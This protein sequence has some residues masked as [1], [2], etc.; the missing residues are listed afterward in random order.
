MNPFTS[1]QQPVVGP[2]RSDRVEPLIRLL[3]R[4]QRWSRS[5]PP[6]FKCDGTENGDFWTTPEIIGLFKASDLF[7]QIL[8]GRDVRQQFPTK[9]NLGTIFDLGVTAQSG[10]TQY[11][12]SDHT[13]SSPM[14]SPQLRPSLTPRDRMMVS[15]IRDCYDHLVCMFNVL[16][17][18]ILQQYQQMQVHSDILNTSGSSIRINSPMEFSD[19]D[20]VQKVA[21][22]FEQVDRAMHEGSARLAHVEPSAQIGQ[23]TYNQSQSERSAYS[24]SS[25][26]AT[27][28]QNS[29]TIETQPS[30]AFQTLR[31]DQ[32]DC[33]NELKCH[34]QCFRANLASLCRQLR[35]D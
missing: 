12:G 15:L 25:S 32:N 14:P 13:W 17:A 7:I 24:R 2:E 4:L 21:S 6:V 34:D 5:W 35:A 28:F 20:A 9:G 16:L 33:L 22:I 29:S 19:L 23:P 27:S 3:F 11:L 31:L 1:N 18:P 30:I 8:Q 10:S 26:G